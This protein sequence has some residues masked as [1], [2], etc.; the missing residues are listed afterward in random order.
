MKSLHDVYDTITVS[1]TITRTYY[2]EELDTI[3]N[4]FTKEKYDQHS[5][6]NNLV[7]F[8]EE[9]RMNKHRTDQDKVL[10]ILNNSGRVSVAHSYNEEVSSF[11]VLEMGTHKV[12]PENAMDTT[13]K[14]TKRSS[15]LIESVNCVLTNGE[16]YDPIYSKP[17]YSR[18]L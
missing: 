7:S 12:D 14:I 3:R 18:F 2:L 8:K 5:T 10:R 15:P 4:H 11:A 9:A 16:K 6:L 1:T 17:N 13:M